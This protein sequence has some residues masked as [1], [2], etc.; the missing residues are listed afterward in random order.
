MADFISRFRAT[1]LKVPGPG[2]GGE[3][4]QVR[5]RA[6]AEC[7]AP[8]G[9]ARSQDFHE[10]AM[11]AERADAVLTR[12]SGQDACKPW[13]KGHKGGFAQ[14]PPLQNRGAGE[15]SAPMGG[16]PEPME[17]GMARRRTYPVKTMQSCAQK[18]PASTAGNPTQGMLQET[19]Q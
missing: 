6:G 11:Y 14:R 16:R 1:C 17:L 5:S 13:S 3:N 18:M 19:T 10:A 4:G 8:G 15:P 9:T 7:E 12:I 2:G